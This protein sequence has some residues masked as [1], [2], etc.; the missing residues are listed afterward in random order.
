[1]F[2]GER[3][4]MFQS[5]RSLIFALALAILLTYMIM[6]A[7]FESLLHPFLIMITI[8]MGAAGAFFALWATGQT[9]NVISIIGMVVLVGLVVDNAIVKIDYTRQ[10]R[11]EGVGLRAAVAESGQVRL[12]PI[13]MS[14]LS[15][16]FGLVPMALGLEAGAELMRPLAITVIG[17][18]TF[19]TFL[20]L[21]IIP[22]LYEAVEARKERKQSRSAA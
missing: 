19:S 1:V 13:L 2:S 17:G 21:I 22:V 14:T 11:R 3:E 6:A 9:I 5:F 8:P 4:E 15:T 10:L 12:R 20:T 7:Q 18:L 16:L